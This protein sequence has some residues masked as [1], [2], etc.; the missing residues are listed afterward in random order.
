MKPTALGV[1]IF[2]GGFTIG[3]R[4]HFKVLAH[5]E[6]GPYGAK[7]VRHNMP[8]IP[9]FDRPADWP[10]ADF[11]GVDVIYGNP[12]CAAWSSAGNFAAAKA[13]ALGEV[14]WRRDPRVDCVRKEFSLLH[15]LRPHFWVWESVTAAYRKGKPLVDELSQEANDLGYAVTHILLDGAYTGL[16]QHRRRFF[17]VAHNVAFH[18]KAPDRTPL[19]VGEVLRAAVEPDP[20]TPY[21]R[22]V[23]PWLKKFVHDIGPG[24]KAMDAWDRFCKR[25]RGPPKT[26]ERGQVVGRPSYLLTRLHGDATGP[27]ILGDVIL[28]PWEDRYL[29]AHEAKLLSG[30]PVDYT[31]QGSAQ[32][33]QIQQAVLPPV[34]DWLGGQIA[35]ALRHNDPLESIGVTLAD[36]LTERQHAVA[37]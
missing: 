36:F 10:I 21:A 8:D 13:K 7:T 2:A 11:V 23:Q 33:K 28:H 17:F 35:T 18:P 25:R 9:I 14:K 12:P 32:H 19:T 4:R 37:R 1:Y 34:G 30:Y 6:D 29:T 5:F 31:F 22:V 27:V 20:P 16:A 3:M 15:A 26:N 24:T